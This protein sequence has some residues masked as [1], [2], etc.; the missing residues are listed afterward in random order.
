MTRALPSSFHLHNGR[1]RVYIKPYEPGTLW[2]NKYGLKPNFSD[3]FI[4]FKTIHL[5][6]NCISQLIGWDPICYI[7][8]SI[9][10]N[11][12]LL[13]L[14][15]MFSFNYTQ[16]YLPV[17]FCVVISVS[18]Q[19]EWLVFSVDLMNTFMLLHTSISTARFGYFDALTPK[20]Y[21]CF[22][23]HPIFQ[24][25][26]I[27]FSASSFSSSISLTDVMFFADLADSNSASF[28][29]LAAQFEASLGS[30]F[31]DVDGQQ[32]VTVSS[33]RWVLCGTEIK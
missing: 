19:F 12:T 26:S 10:L 9:L 7:M 3:F 25:Y 21:M 23:N 6:S 13:E 33:F 24:L 14:S 16:S 22:V 11:G 4:R 15:K 18:A 2:M 27:L 8:F 20:C 29:Q 30:L 5:F 17:Y 28:S 31:T 32:I 1:A